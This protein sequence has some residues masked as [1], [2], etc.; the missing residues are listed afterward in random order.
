MTVSLVEIKSLIRL[1]LMFIPLSQVS[2]EL[3][4][5][6]AAS[7]ASCVACNAVA[8]LYLSP[9]YSKEAMVAAAISVCIS[10]RLQPPRVCRGLVDSFKVIIIHL[11]KI[12][13]LSM[14]V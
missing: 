9:L 6:K 11:S 5:G 8:S 3:K 14:T 13:N 7:R 1:F 12:E 2:E 10:F 4:S